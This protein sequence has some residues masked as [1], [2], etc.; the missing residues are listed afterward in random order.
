[1]LKSVE[2]NFAHLNTHKSLIFNS[3]VNK[4]AKYCYFDKN[5]KFIAIFQRTTNSFRNFF[6][7]LLNFKLKNK[8]QFKIRLTNKM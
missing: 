3:L 1:M 2:K 8:L 6:F 4:L 7:E 5:V